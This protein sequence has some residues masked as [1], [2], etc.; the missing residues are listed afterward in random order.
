M[1]TIGYHCAH[2]QHPPSELLRLA[3]LAESAGFGAGMCSD[4]LHPWLPEQGQSGF[5]WSWLGSALE[6]TGLS[7]G[8]VC[9][10]GDRYHP[11]IV[12]QASATLAQMYPGR[13]WVSL[14]SGE[15]LNEHVTGAPWPAKPQRNARLRECVE[16]IRALWRGEVVDHDGL[17][18]VR[19]ARLYTTPAEPPPI[20]AAALTEET[21]RWAGGWADAL[22]TVA[23]EPDA[24]RRV[25][26][27]FREGGG[28]GKPLFL[29]VALSYA[30]ADDEAL[31]NAWREWRQA[32]LDPAQL[33]DLPTPE[34]FAEACRDVSPEA[35]RERLR[36]SS[37]PARFVD[38][39]AR[40]AELG[41][42]RIF[43]HNLGRNQE[44][45]IDAFAARVLPALR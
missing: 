22:V 8:T 11:A 28:E 4:H 9:A 35:L 26:D 32:G 36:I 44:A 10:P 27:A 18:T 2:E 14:A 16:L 21:A 12:A 6:A 40:D 7:F 1:A 15:A 19:R 42:E 24:L 17:V 43:L 45:F 38:W 29:Q 31:R 23:A 37:D 3:R 39:L 20:V 41:F 33:A 30:D 13:F 25:V 34:A 5:S